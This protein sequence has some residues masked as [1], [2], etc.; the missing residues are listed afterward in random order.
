M[1][2]YIDTTEYPGLI[3]DMKNYDYKLS[4]KRKKEYERK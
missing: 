2:S 3:Y 1:T 4:I